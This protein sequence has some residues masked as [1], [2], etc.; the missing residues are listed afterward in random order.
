MTQNLSGIRSEA[1]IGRWSSY[2]I[3]PPRETSPAAKSE[4]KRMFSQAIFY[5]YGGYIELIRFKKYYRMP[6]GHEHVSFVFSSA[7]RDIFS[8][9]FLR[10]RL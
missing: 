2:I 7:L 3:V 10:I 5:R 8:Q 9:S 1:L 4:E 6:S